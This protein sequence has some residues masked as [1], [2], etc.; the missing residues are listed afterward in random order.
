MKTLAVQNLTVG[1]LNYILEKGQWGLFQIAIKG[2]NATGQQLPFDNVNVVIRWNGKDILNA[3]YNFL[4]YLSNVYGGYVPITNTQGGSIDACCFLPTGLWFDPSN[5]WDVGDE[6]KVEFQ[7]TWDA[8]KVSSGTIT[9][10]GKR[11]TGMMSYIHGIYKRT[12]LLGVGDNFDNI[13]VENI[14]NYYIKLPSPPPDINHLTNIQIARDNKIVIDCSGRHLLYYSN[15]IHLMEVNNEFFV[16]IDFVE[17]KDIKDAV[18]KN[19]SIKITNTWGTTTWNL[20][21]YY[22]VLIPRPDKLEISLARSLS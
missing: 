18:G 16:A 19:L 13:E 8:S 14:T 7:I 9:I 17:T 2:T 3:D 12:I 10:L 15:W 6:D 11:K 4:L 1:Q 22:S 20:N 21:T 5:V